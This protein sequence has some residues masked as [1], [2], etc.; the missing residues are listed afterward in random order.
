MGKLPR[1]PLK[2]EGGHRGGEPPL[3]RRKLS[4][5]QHILQRF[6]QIPALIEDAKFAMGLDLI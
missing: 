3:L 2:A 6:D 5:L 4:E 1:L